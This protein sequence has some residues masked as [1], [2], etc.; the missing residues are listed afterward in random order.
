MVSAVIPA[1][2]EESTIGNVLGTLKGISEIDEIIAVS[3]GSTDN[4]ASAAKK[5]GVKVIE[6]VENRGKGAAV[7][8]ALEV[9]KGNVILFLDADLIGLTKDHVYKLLNPV[10]DNR[11]DMTIGVFTSGRFSTNFSHMVSPH[12]SGQRAV[13]KSILDR[14]ENIGQTG[15]GLEIALTVHAREEGVRVEE[16]ELE[17]MTHVMKEE[18][19]GIIKGFGHRLKM[20]WQIYK[21]VR[22]AKR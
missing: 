14:I 1:Y 15:Y 10:L 18:K 12:L 7:K 16:V 9:C 4:T 20:Y 5:F 8:A 21:G 13:K 2:N 19:F 3:D 6:F 17:G 11:A 22:L